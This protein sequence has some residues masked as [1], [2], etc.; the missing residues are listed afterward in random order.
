[1]FPFDY[2]RSRRVG[3]SHTAQ[4]RHAVSKILRKLSKFVPYATAVVMAYQ[5]YDAASA[6]CK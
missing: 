4:R 2:D 5:I 3:D 6:S 1:M